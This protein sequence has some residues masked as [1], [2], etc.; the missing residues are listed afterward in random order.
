MLLEQDPTLQTLPH[1]SSQEPTTHKTRQDTNRNKQ[2]T[3]KIKTP[4]EL[5]FHILGQNTKNPFR[6][7][8]ETKRNWNR[9]CQRKYHGCWRRRRSDRKISHTARLLRCNKRDEGERNHNAWTS[10]FLLGLW[11]FRVS[12]DLL[13]HH[14]RGSHPSDHRFRKPQVIGIFEKMQKWIG[15]SKIGNLVFM[16]DGVVGNFGNMN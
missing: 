4:N 5:T 14:S 15:G 9:K 10:A 12:P 11:D 8:D 2:H 6:Q 1:V 3:R 7:E 13:T 16:D